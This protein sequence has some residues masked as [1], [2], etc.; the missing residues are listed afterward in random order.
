MGDM[1]EAF[2]IMK[3]RKQAA[4]RQFGINCPTCTERLPRA[5]PTIMLPQQ[6]CKVCGYQDPR[7]RSSM[8]AWQAD[9]DR[10]N[11]ILRG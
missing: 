9:W 3:E 2:R 4:R 10:E 6:V 8:R 5:H 1:V 11:G 7:P